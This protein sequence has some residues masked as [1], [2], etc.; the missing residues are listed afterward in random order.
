[1]VYI[2]TTVRCDVVL[3]RHERDIKRFHGVAYKLL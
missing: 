2:Q 3:G 1:M